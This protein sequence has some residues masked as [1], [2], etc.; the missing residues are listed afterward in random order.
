MTKFLDGVALAKMLGLMNCHFLDG[1]PDSAPQLAVDASK[2]NVNQD[3]HRSVD[4]VSKH[5][6]NRGVHC[7]GKRKRKCCMRVGVSDS[8]KL[9][10]HSQG[11]WLMRN[12]AMRCCSKTLGNCLW[13]LVKPDNAVIRF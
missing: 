7:N 13:V 10:F 11:G 3:T 6:V 2:H 8:T 12:Y 1:R 4:S 9:S 5:I